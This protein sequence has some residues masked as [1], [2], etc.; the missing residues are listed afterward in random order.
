[1][2]IKTSLTLDED[3]RA[4]LTR[5]GRGATAQ[6]REDLRVLAAL[7]RSWRRRLEISKEELDLLRDLLNGSLMPTEVAERMNLLLAMEVE[8]GEPD[9]LSKKWGVD[10]AALAAKIRDAHPA[11]A[12]ALWDEVREWWVAQGQDE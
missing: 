12:W 9:G 11:D 8:D 7:R 10:M 4:F 2:S 3:T 6:T 1:M 5:A